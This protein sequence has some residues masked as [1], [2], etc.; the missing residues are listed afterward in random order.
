MILNSKMMT[1]ASQLNVLEN[2]IKT[3]EQKK[4]EDPFMIDPTNSVTKSAIQ[5]QLQ[6]L[7]LS[8]EKV[9]HW[10]EQLTKANQDV[11]LSREKRYQLHEKIQQKIIRQVAL[12]KFIKIKKEKEKQQ[13]AN[14]KKMLEQKIL[15]QDHQKKLRLMRNQQ[16][17]QQLQSSSVMDMI[18]FSDPTDLDGEARSGDDDEYKYNSGGYDSEE[19]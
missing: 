11:E 17:L 4:Y 19:G 6:K 15:I 13:E 3:N 7:L 8:H 12:Q 16:Q 5:E 9:A 2:D 1:T 18:D 14:K 10:E